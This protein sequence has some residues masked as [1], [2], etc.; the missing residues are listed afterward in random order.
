MSRARLQAGA[1]LPIIAVMHLYPAMV[2]LVGLAL[3]AGCNSAHEPSGDSGSSIDAASVIDAAPS[4]D[5]GSDTSVDAAGVLDVQPMNATFTTCAC[6]HGCAPGIDGTFTVTATNA[7]A[8][9]HAITITQITLIPI[10]T[11]GGPY[12]T[13]TNGYFH[14]VPTTADGSVTIPAGGSVSLAV[15]VYLDIPL[16][17]PGTDR[18]EVAATIDG[19]PVTYVLA[20]VP[21]NMTSGC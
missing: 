20:A 9:V 8:M 3:S 6:H 2:V 13:G 1:T 21:V 10:G 7:S 11:P 17:Q 12:V 19:S 15:T 16:V 14:V 18:V 5:G 4:I